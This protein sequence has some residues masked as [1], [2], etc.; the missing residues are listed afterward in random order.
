MNIDLSRTEL[1]QLAATLGTAIL[2]CDANILGEKAL[3]GLEPEAE[4]NA[5]LLEAQ[6]QAL[7]SV[8]E[9]TTEA[10]NALEVPSSQMRLDIGA[11]E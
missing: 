4:T 1:Q 11:S 6:K 5:A 10:L 2:F 9:K 7:V 3:V 8:L